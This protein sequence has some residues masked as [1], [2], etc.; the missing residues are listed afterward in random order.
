MIDIQVK[1]HDRF[2]L[3]L[4]V[5]FVAKRKIEISD[6]VM[7][8]W[9]FVPNS[10]DI[11][12]RT[13]QK[14]DFYRDV[15]SNVRLITPVYLLKNIAKSNSLPFKL[16]EKAC[17]QMAKSPTQT[18]IREYEYQI[19]MFSSIVKSSI[20]DAYNHIKNNKIADD[21]FFLCE[22][23]L[24]NSIE[25]IDKYRN[26][27][28]IVNAPTVTPTVLEYFN[29]GDE[30]ICNV[31]EQHIFRLYKFLK[32]SDNQTFKLLENKIKDVLSRE[33]SYKKEMNY[34]L[35]EVDNP[36][37]NRDFIFRAGMLKKYIESELYLIARKKRNTF[38]I[39]Q[40]LFS[41]A[42][43]ISMI[44]ATIIAFSFQMKYG[45]FTLPLFVALVVSYMMK[46]RIKDLMRYYFAHKLGSK[47]F[48]HKIKISMKDEH[49]GWIKEG[50]DFITDDK[51]PKVVM[52]Q[53]GRSSLLAAGNRKLDEKII[54]YRKRVRLN[55][56]QF[57][58]ISPFPLKG[59]NDIIRIN[60]S[61]YI[62]NMDNPEVPLFGNINGENFEIVSGEKI[63]YINF[64][65]QCK[66]EDQS[67]YRRYRIMCNRDGIKD[68]KSDS[69]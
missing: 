50:F 16:L 65:I 40:V 53:R 25:I 38:L 41:L 20:R 2:S 21:Q 45:N 22:E 62:R 58:K 56:K 24:A 66:Y 7:N 52:D 31:I 35:V 60:F 6:F 47:F 10:L 15:R 30:F 28:K 57:N 67:E 17:E 42:A 29:F 27:R 13:Y 14:E 11:N 37:C 48:D 19:K 5:G 69:F 46:D 26:I 8:T 59:I 3:E 1:I 4:K 61:D 54:L 44:F 9:I 33:Y 49:I 23:M 63:Y 36:D 55:R 64:V 68:V 32:E 34:A 18:N 39:E 51:V 43:G 12:I